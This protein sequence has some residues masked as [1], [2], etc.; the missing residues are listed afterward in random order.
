MA[1]F[2]FDEIIFGPVNSRRLG[3]SLGINLLPVKTKYCNFNCLYCECGFTPKGYGR[4]KNE[5]PGSYKVLTSLENT[6]R[7]FQKEKREIDT[8]TFAGNGEP[9]LHP[10]F[11][12]II[13]GALGIRNKYYP[14]AK[15]AV[16]SNATLISR[17]E[18]ITA[19]SKIEYNI[20]KLDS[21]NEKTIKL[22]NCP[23]G[24]F[25]LNNLLSDLKKIKTGLT[26]Q[27]L[28]VKGEYKG[29]RFDNSSDEEVSNWLNVLQILQ[30]WLVMIYTI[31]RDTPI[32]SIHKIPE[33]R[34][35]DIALQ[36]LQKGI[37]VS[38]SG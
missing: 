9:T 33:G 10:D 2:L 16:L 30:P 31:S 21:V 1:T 7:D 28:F 35:H 27:T 38:V 25:S 4:Y 20:L 15:I 3:E 5:L 6:L 18:I 13:N 37:Q 17:P 29:K 22:I 23:A 11:P 8:I 34:L 26:I 14:K 24:K 12:E 32:D 36:V 19:L